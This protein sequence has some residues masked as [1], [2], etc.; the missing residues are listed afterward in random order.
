MLIYSFNKVR[1]DP[2][3]KSAVAFTA[4][5]VHIKIFHVFWIPPY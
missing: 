1:D 3:I 4:K 5:N 2:G